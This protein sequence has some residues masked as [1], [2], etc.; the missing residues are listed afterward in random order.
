MSQVHH[1]NLE[2][3]RAWSPKHLGG[4]RPSHHWGF[5][6]LWASWVFSDPRNE[7][8]CLVFV[9][10]HRH[11]GSWPREFCGRSPHPSYRDWGYL[12]SNWRIYEGKP[13]G[14]IWSMRGRRLFGWYHRSTLL[15]RYRVPIRKAK[16]QISSGSPI[17]D[18]SIYHWQGGK[19]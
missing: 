4:E 12:F 5:T 1:G 11:V 18:S 7:S 6:E 19:Y 13:C 2:R 8:T 14:S 17:E 16:D 10:Y 15:I 3:K 9:V